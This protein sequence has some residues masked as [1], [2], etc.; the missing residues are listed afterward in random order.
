[1]TIEEKI[2][3]DCTNNHSG[4]SLVSAPLNGNNY[5]CWERSIKIAIGARQKL[6]YIDGSCTKPE[7]NK[8]AIEQWQKNDYMKNDTVATYFTRLKKLWDELNTLDPLPVCSCGASKKMSEKNASYQFMQFL[9]GLND[10]YD[11][12]K[13][14]IL[15]MD[16]LPTAAK[17]YSMV[18]KVEKQRELNSEGTELESEGVMAVQ[19]TESK[20]QGNSR[21]NLKKGQVTDKKQL[22]CDYCKKK[23]HLK[24]GCFELVGYPDWYKNMMDQRKAGN[25]PTYSRVTDTRMNQQANNMQTSLNNE[26][27]ANLSRLIRK[28]MLR[29]MQDQ[30]STQMS[31][32]ISEFQGY[33]GKNSI[34]SQAWIVDSGASAHTC[35]SMSNLENLHELNSKVYVKL[36][37]ATSQHVKISREVH[38][39]DDII[40]KD[41]LYVPAFKHNLLSVGKLCKDNHVNVHF[42]DKTCVVQDPLTKKVIS[43]GRQQ[44]RLYVL[45]RGPQ[46]YMTN[47]LRETLPTNEENVFTDASNVVKCRSECNKILWHNSEL[48]EDRDSNEPSHTPTDLNQEPETITE[49]HRRSTRLTSRPAWMKDYECYNI[50]EF[51]NFH[52]T[53]E[54]ACFVKNLSNMQ[55]QRDFKQAQEKVEWRKAMQEEIDAL[56]K[57]RTWKVTDLPPNRRTIGFT[58]RIFLAVA[59]G[60]GWPMHHLDVNNAFLHGTIDE[61]IYMDAPQGYNIPQGKVCKLE[62]SLY[63]LKQA[64]RKWNEE[65]TNK[66]REFGFEQCSHDH[67]LF[68][69][70]SGNNLIALIVYVDDIL[71]TSSSESH[72]MIVK[73]YLDK[74]FTVKHL[75]NAKYFLG[76]EL[77]RSAEGLVV[78]QHKYAQDIVKDIGLSNGKDVTTPLP[79]GLKFN[80]ETGAALSDPSRYRRLIG[81]LLYLGFTRPDLWY[82]VQQLSQHLQHP[83][84]KHWN[85]AVHVVRYLKRSLSTGLFFPSNTNFSLRVLCDADWATCPLTRKSL[86]GFCIFI[87]ET[88]ISWKTKKQT[89]VARSSAEVEYRSMATT[90]CEVTWLIY[91]LRNLNVE[92]KTPVPFYCDNKAVLHITA[93]PVFHER[94]KHL[95]IDCHVVRNKYKEGLIQPTFLATKQQVADVFTKALPCNTFLHLRSKLS[96]VNLSPSTTCGGSDEI[97]APSQSATAL[98]H[99]VKKRD[100]EQR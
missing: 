13:N 54:H 89:T 49:T 39:N 4:V 43:V 77:A 85:A 8:E 52:M 86:T 98:A 78:T 18:H 30:S 33:A 40:L 47:P 26:P 19:A 97:Q 58:I 79:L 90:T 56:E 71:I 20:R 46:G 93:N 10:I 14:Q 60:K 31:S 38:I 81:R 94:T 35:T 63:G 9:M 2:P 7:E 16:P 44:G 96:L 37:D 91:I 83:C 66:V 41:V 73:D 34:T 80:I 23:G 32:S 12:V 65:F 67:C 21:T 51:N 99:S 72:I 5:L 76:L 92:V 48:I 70:G 22:Q 69:K 17:A 3:G 57:N 29:I 95:E 75:E 11:H 36:P 82:A 87:G 25:K 61:D 27:D 68:V 28:E 42:T 50:D 1:M 64:S 84:E 6:S 53:H 55:E 45:E 88:P 62:K 100:E 15:L 74:I 59:V 24:E